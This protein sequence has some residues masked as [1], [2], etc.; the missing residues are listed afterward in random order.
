MSRRSIAHTAFRPT[1]RSSLR[2]TLVAAAIALTALLV[3]FGALAVASSPGFPDVPVSHPYY[4][5][6]TDLASRD[7]IGGKAD[8][9]FWPDDPVTRQQFAKMIVG[10]GG[11]PVSESD[12]C[13]FADV[14]KGGPATLFPDNFVAVCAAHGITTGKTPTTFDPGGKITRYQAVSM[15]ARAA[16]DLEPGLLVTPPTDFT[17]S[18]AW[19]NDPTHGANAKRAEYNGLLEGLDLAALSP[20]GNMSR[21][22]VA[23]VLHNLLG[24]LGGGGEFMPPPVPATKAIGYL[25]AAMGQFHDAFDVYTDADAA[26]NHFPARGRMASVAGDQTV[27]T[28]NEA[29]TTNPHSGLTCIKATFRSQGENWGG[30]YFMNGVLQGK[31]REPRENWGT[32]PSAGIDLRGARQ[33]TFWARGAS[34]G[35]RVEFFAFNLGRDEGGVPLEAY[36]DSSTKV[37]TGYVT[38]SNSWKQYTI[39]VQGKNLSYVLGGF[40]WVSKAGQNGG[41]DITFYI[42]DV[43]YDKARLSE[44]RFVL[45]YQTI[46]SGK[47]VDRI[48]RNVAFTYDNA[49]AL[50]AFLAD[51]KTDRAKLIADAFIYALNHDRY[52]TDGRVRN[53][54]QAGDLVLPPGWVPNGK[55]GTVRLPG[56]YDTTADTPS[57][58]EDEVQVSTS[59]GNQAWAMLAL[60]AYYETQDGAEYLTAVK[61]MGDWVETNC[62]DT[63]GA[64]GYTAGFEGWET[65]PPAKLTYKATEHNIDLYTA[66]QRL[67][68]ITGQQKWH[69]RA[70]HAKAFVLAMWDSSE[71]KFWTG[72]KADGTTI[73][74]AVVP[75]DIQAWALLAL[76]DEGDAYRASLTY[77]ENHCAVGQGFDFNQ[78]RD[79]IWYEGTAQ[80][81]EAYAFERQGAAWQSRIDL[82][83]Q[84]QDPSGGIVAASV[85]ELT[86]GF[87]L[88]D[89]SARWLYYR[90]L[91]V[92]ATAWLAL[93]EMMINPF[94]FEHQDK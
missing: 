83:R 68:L 44:P 25:T 10:T 33:L 82:L 56:W 42:D 46:N 4:A 43:T 87:W 48:L 85:E 47:D 39:D 32:Y 35:E 74:P 49:L 71:G 18:G 15:V 64:G 19:G 7:I 91:H 54:Y 14:E 23:Q 34:G 26:G 8:G 5:A 41:K 12:L 62:R 2:K 31:D 78:D 79:G 17:A 88:S 90:R 81:A 38:L 76:G 29:W 27:P 3:C 50:V 16:D 20:A 13:S 66:F 58:F 94:W 65:D 59:T 24:K 40:G 57:W 72:T 30:W 37:T 70:Q 53:A 69:D 9:R 61:Q 36:P 60:L 84:A 89:G 67:Y 1:Y 11:Y 75:V 51:G 22:E 80:M 93:A 6:I 52:Y 45:S 28:M 55:T 77:A 86:T 73:D 63:R 92:G 21:G